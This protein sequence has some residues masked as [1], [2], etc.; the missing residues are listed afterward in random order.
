MYVCRVLIARYLGRIHF[1][2]KLS[3]IF[4]YYIMTFYTDRISSQM[5]YWSTSLFSHTRFESRVTS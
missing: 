2:L 3:Y 1:V 4:T 5:I